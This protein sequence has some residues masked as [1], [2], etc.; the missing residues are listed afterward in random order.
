VVPS[1]NRRLVRLPGNVNDP[2]FA[3]ALVT[4]FREIAA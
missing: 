1:S 2:A 4:A 3:T